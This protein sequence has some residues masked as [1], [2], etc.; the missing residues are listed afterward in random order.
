MDHP[1]FSFVMKR[2]FIALFV[3]AGMASVLGVSASAAGSITATLNEPLIDYTYTDD[4]DDPFESF[5]AY[6]SYAGRS[7][8]FWTSED[9]DLL[10]IPDIYLVSGMHFYIQGTTALGTTVRSNTVTYLPG[11]SLP[12]VGSFFDPEV[13]ISVEWYASD[14]SWTTSDVYLVV[15]R[16]G[17]SD[18]RM[19]VAHN[20]NWARTE[21]GLYMLLNDSG[22]FI[23]GAYLTVFLTTTYQGLSLDSRYGSVTWEN[24]FTSFTPIF[25]RIDGGFN[26]SVPQKL[27]LSW[28]VDHL[29]GSVS[30]EIYWIDSGDP[31]AG[32]WTFFPSHSIN[33]AVASREFFDSLYGPDALNLVLTRS[34]KCRVVFRTGTGS[35]ATVYYSKWLVLNG[36]D[37][38]GA[39]E[40]VIDPL[41]YSPTDAQI[42]RDIALIYRGVKETPVYRYVFSGLVL[43]IPFMVGVFVIKKVH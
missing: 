34:V 22:M 21:V 39:I 23:D 24:P 41:L 32:S 33:L 35:N 8:Q 42:D 31:I 26:V 5:A 43:C 2:L 19:L 7:E 4:P 15:R 40:T 36:L 20:G 25:D 1:V 12:D 11:R 27:Y 16:S 28:G 17:Y 18:V 13:G 38:F 6:S 9:P 29:F 37:G 3:I 10:M 30:L 14:I